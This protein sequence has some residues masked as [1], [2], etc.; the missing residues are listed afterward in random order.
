MARVTGSARISRPTRTI[1][2]QP[3]DGE[4]IDVEVPTHVAGLLDFASGPIGVLVTTFDAQASELPRIEIY[5]TTATLSVPDPNTFGGPVRLRHATDDQWEEI[6]ITR[7]YTEQSRGIG[8]AD[9]AVALRT[10][11][12]QRA[13]GALAYH[14]LDLMHAI[15]E[16]SASGQHV[17]IASG[18]ERPEAMPEIIHRLRSWNES[19]QLHEN[20]E[21]SIPMK[22]SWR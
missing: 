18:V 5:G 9:M 1:S 13:S 8:L 10:G 22:V 19:H 15:H 17:A 16:A 14:V 21:E 11:S 2:S 3:R 4:V 6:P 20:T 7:P 12:P